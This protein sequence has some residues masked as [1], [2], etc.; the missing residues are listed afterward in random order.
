VAG[1]TF[2]DAG[3]GFLLPNWLGQTRPTLINSTNDLVHGTTGLELRWT[4]PVVGTPLRINY[5]FNLL[6]LN[7]AV[8]MPDGSVFR[9]H[10]HLGA[11]GW[12][13]GPLF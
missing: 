10:D 13:L 1:A 9:L 8:L 3:S 4:L 12:G 6:R 7:R 5:S 11:L 2:F